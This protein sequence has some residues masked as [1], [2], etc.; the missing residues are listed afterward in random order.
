MLTSEVQ[1]AAKVWSSIS[2]ILFVPHTNQEY[3]AMVHLSDNLIDEVDED[4][5]HPLA[6]LMALFGPPLARDRF[7]GMRTH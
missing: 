5:E 6:S 4:E 3:Q 7:P 2:K 1:K